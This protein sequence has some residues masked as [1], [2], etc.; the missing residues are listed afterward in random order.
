MLVRSQML[1]FNLLL[2]VEKVDL[3]LRN[4]EGFFVYYFLIVL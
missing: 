4:P 2:V 1:L 3:S